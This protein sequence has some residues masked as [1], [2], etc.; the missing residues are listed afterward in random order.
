MLTPSTME[1]EESIAE[2]DPNA[3]KSSSEQRM[4]GVHLVEGQGDQR[5]WELYSETADG[6][7]GQGVWQLKKVKVIFYARTGDS[8]KVIGDE[9][10]INVSTKD[11]DITGHV[12]TSSTNGYEVRT[13]EVHYV[14]QDKI[15]KI[16]THLDV[17][18]PQDK[19]GTRLILKSERMQTFLESSLMILEEQVYAERNLTTSS[20]TK[21][22]Q[23]HSG[24]AHISGKSNLLRFFDGVHVSYEKIQ[25]RAP[26]AFFAYK[27]K[28]NAP[29]SII[30]NGGVQID[31]A[32][33]QATAENLKIDV[34]QDQYVLKGSPKVIQN[35]DE[36]VGEQITF[37][38]GGNKVRVDK[39]HALVE[40]EVEKDKE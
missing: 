28:S 27:E 26:E 20:G 18:G 38:N 33:R 2:I 23:I 4:E 39:A 7:V 6:F 10:K 40:D 15:L 24:K 13:S 12:F 9:G 3:A 35:G 14:S 11:I 8:Y 21:L 32:D 36:I 25:V 31:G 29:D 37:L 17:K 5:E 19:D 1:H 16:P 30:M 34:S 22:L